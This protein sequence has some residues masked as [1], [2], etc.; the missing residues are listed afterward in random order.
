MGK[1]ES[2]L[3]LETST[4]IIMASQLESPGPECLSSIEIENYTMM[5][6]EKEIEIES[7]YYNEKF[8]N[9]VESHLSVCPFCREKYRKKMRY[10]NG[11]NA[12][13]E[14]KNARDLALISTF[15]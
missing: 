15:I 8:V 4:A 14:L 10:T 13:Q 6:D 9:K 3:N 2:K 7:G 12:S 11:S 5:K 1:K